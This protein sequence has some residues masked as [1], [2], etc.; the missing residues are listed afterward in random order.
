VHSLPAVQE[1]VSGGSVEI[2]LSCR[3]RRT[4][5]IFFLRKSANFHTIN[6]ETS[7]LCRNITRFRPFFRGFSS[8]FPVVF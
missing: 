6:Y 3:L 5:Q 8:K 1:G 2:I 4:S 7:S